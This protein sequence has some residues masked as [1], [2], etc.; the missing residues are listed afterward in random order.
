[1]GALT[2]LVQRNNV[3]ANNRF[4]KNREV[5]QILDILIDHRLCKRLVC[6]RWVSIDGGAQSRAY[7]KIAVPQVY[8]ATPG[9]AKLC[10]GTGTGLT[11]ALGTYMAMK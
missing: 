8:A 1:M 3:H 11:Y 7:S 6:H 9:R 4:P 5:P 2:A 10:S